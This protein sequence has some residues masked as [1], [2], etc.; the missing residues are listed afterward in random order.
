MDLRRRMGELLDRASAGER[1]V[2]ERDRRP[3]AVL[4]PYEDAVRLEESHADARARALAALD[5]L[6]SL[7]LTSSWPSRPTPASSPP[8][9][10]WLPRP[11]T[12]PSSSPE[13]MA[14]R[15]S[16]LP[17]A[18]IH[19]GRPGTARSRT[20][21]SCGAMPSARRSMRPPE[22]WSAAPATWL[23]TRSSGGLTRCGPRRA[24]QLARNNS[25][26]QG[27]AVRRRCVHATIVGRWRQ[28]THCSPPAASATNVGTD[29]RSEQA[30]PALPRDQDQSPVAHG[31]AR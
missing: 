31:G 14:S 30:P 18:P 9:P 26:D 5:R 3:L 12:G 17:T 29:G 6:E 27:L 19:R 21:Q 4:V 10:S 15:R 7:A 1:I 11:V 20:W 23:P 2:V 24:R 25:G 28:S 16:G 13:P 8:T 22:P